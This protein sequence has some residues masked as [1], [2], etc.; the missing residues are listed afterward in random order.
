[1][2]NQWLAPESCPS[3]AVLVETVTAPLLIQHTAPVCFEMD[4]DPLLEIPA[5]PNQTAEL[6]RVLVN[7]LL[8]EMPEGGELMMTA[9]RSADTIELVLADSGCDADARPK[10]F[11]MAAAAIGADIDWQNGPQGGAVVKITFGRPGQSLRRAA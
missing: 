2:S 4:V 3:F 11:P 9:K 5:D 8:A 10:N 7:Q 1:M 6:L